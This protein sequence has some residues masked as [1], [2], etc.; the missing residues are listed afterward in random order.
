MSFQK[1]LNEHPATEADDMER[2]VDATKHKY[3]RQVLQTFIQTA[4]RGSQAIYFRGPFLNSY[5]LAEFV[6]EMHLRGQCELV[7]RRIKIGR[8]AI[9]EYM[10]VKR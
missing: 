1:K 9:Y 2:V 10:M 8:T 3:P 6:R 5:S 7:Q 4:P